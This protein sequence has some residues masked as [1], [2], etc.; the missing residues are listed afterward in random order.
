M[1][2]LSLALAGL[3]TVGLYAAAPVHASTSAT[4]LERIP[5]FD[6]VVV[7]VEENESE[8]T[9][10][11]PGSPA[12]YLNSLL[13]KGVFNPSYFATGHASLD[14]YISMVSGQPGNG[15]TNSDCLTVSL[16][17]CAQSTRTL[18]KGRHLGDQFDAAH[19]TWKSYMDGTPTPCFHGPYSAAPPDVLAPDPYQGDSQTPPAKD[20]ADRHNPF[21]YFPDFIGNHA[22]CVAHQRPYT[23]LSGDLAAN[24]LPAFSFITPDTCHDGHDDPCSNGSPGGLVSAD[25]WLQQNVPALLSYLS[26]HNGLLIITFD[27][28]DAAGGTSGRLCPRCAGGGLGGQVG[29][30]FL[31]PRLPQGAVVTTRYDHFSLLRTIEDS[32]G[33]S[34]HLNLAN[35]AHAMKDIFAG[36][37]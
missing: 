34:E 19:V 7:L 12:V 16:Y 2:P 26:S 4:R 35:E 5:H 30:V 20:Y 6:H 23:E 9:T 27:E 18:N 3:L 10:F 11:G 22:R 32:F 21:I 31:S 25:A 28:D 29:A 15:L 1:K 37:Y 8:A 17:T 36:Y 33:I 13:S 24:R 14:N